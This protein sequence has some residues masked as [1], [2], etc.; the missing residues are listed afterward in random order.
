MF[1]LRVQYFQDTAW[2][3]R[4][5]RF[6]VFTARLARL[7]AS[8]TGICFMGSWFDGDDYQWHQ[9]QCNQRTLLV[10]SCFHACKAGTPSTPHPAIR[11]QKG[12]S[13]LMFSTS[14]HHLLIIRVILTT[15]DDGFLLVTLDFPLFDE[16]F[17]LC[18]DVFQKCRS[19][20]VVWIL[21]H[22]PSMNGKVKDFGFMTDMHFSPK[23]SSWL[24]MFA[25][26]RMVSIIVLI[27]SFCCS[28]KVEQVEPI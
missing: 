13:S 16:F 9:Y 2:P 6:R 18:S 20:F 5:E 19:R 14:C 17:F 22:K 7:G 4:T 3:M 25:T 11:H 12:I 1:P 15:E 10:V 21:W 27:D 28:L 24:A 8:D 26:M 23:D